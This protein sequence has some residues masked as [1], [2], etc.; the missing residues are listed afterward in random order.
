[1][2]VLEDAEFSGRLL[3][4]GSWPFH[5]FLALAFLYFS[6][7]LSRKGSGVEQELVTVLKDNERYFAVSVCMDY[8]GQCR[9]SFPGNIQSSNAWKRDSE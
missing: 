9:G 5:L 8:L 7:K 3:S 4:P 2:L 1:M 6:V